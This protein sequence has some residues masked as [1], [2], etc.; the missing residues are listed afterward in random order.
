MSRPHPGHSAREEQTCNALEEASTDPLQLLVKMRQCGETMEQC[1]RDQCDMRRCRQPRLE[2]VDLDYPL[3]TYWRQQAEGMQEQTERM[4]LEIMPETDAEIEDAFFS[5]YGEGQDGGYWGFQTHPPPPDSGLVHQGLSRGRLPY[6][7]LPS[8][9]EVDE[10]KSRWNATDSPSGDYFKGCASP[11]EED[12]MMGSMDL[13]VCLSAGLKI[14]TSQVTFLTH[15]TDSVSCLASAINVTCDMQENKSS[16]IVSEAL[17][18]MALWDCHWLAQAGNLDTLPWDNSCPQCEFI[19]CACRVCQFFRTSKGDWK[20]LQCTKLKG[21][22]C[23]QCRVCFD[24]SGHWCVKRESLKGC[25]G[26]SVEGR[27]SGNHVTMTSIMSTARQIDL[28][29]T[30]HTQVQLSVHQMAHERKRIRKALDQRWQ[31]RQQPLVMPATHL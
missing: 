3:I 31:N 15:T 21:C 20:D 30:C 1:F 4:R 10:T 23:V 11:M 13:S 14:T 2:R 9:A 24:S 5:L 8:L 17:H 26:S 18:L 7:P 19:H 29:P 28:L 27:G 12:S 25:T 22:K 6:I 16:H